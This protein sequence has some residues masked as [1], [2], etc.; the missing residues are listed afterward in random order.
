MILAADSEGPDQIAHSRSLTWAFAVRE[1]P[2]GT[3]SLG[4]AQ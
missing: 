1:C 2:Y 3:V 4:E